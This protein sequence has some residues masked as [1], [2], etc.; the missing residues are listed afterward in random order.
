M[1]EYLKWKYFSM[2]T[3]SKIY[4]VENF[5]DYSDMK[6]F[7]LKEPTKNDILNDLKILNKFNCDSFKNFISSYN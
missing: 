4:D 3:W 6:S 7:N 5:P 1:L 2:L